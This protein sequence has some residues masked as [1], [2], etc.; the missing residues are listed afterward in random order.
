MGARAVG[1]IGLR[2]QT[3][4]RPVIAASRIALSAV[5]LALVVAGSAAAAECASS[6]ERAALDTRM[7]QSHAM[8]AALSCQQ[9]S[10]YNAFALKFRS[11]LVD[12][13]TALRAFFRRAYGAAGKVQLDSFVTGLAN[14]VSAESLANQLAFCAAAARLFDDLDRIQPKQLT[15]FV[16]DQP[17]AGDHG[18]AECAQR[19]SAN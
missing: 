19:A 18:I 5:A 11:E 7:L 16:T 6:A 14:R 13:G 4:L 8:V 15:R 3:S 10:R 12:H 2:N 1:D 17:F 9:Q